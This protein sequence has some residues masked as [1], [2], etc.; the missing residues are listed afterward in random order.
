MLYLFTEYSSF[1]CRLEKKEIL[2]TYYI[3]INIYN[4]FITIL[5]EYQTK[6]IMISL[7]L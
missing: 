4:I 6:N 2:D 1:L 5:V 3:I 7:N